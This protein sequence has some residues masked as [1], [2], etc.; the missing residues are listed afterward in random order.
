MLWNGMVVLE[1]SVKAERYK[2]HAEKSLTGRNR[3]NERDVEA[4][5][6]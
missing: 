5:I 6:I 4:R 3:V 1:S 2:G